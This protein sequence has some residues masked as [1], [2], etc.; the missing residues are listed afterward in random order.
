MPTIAEVLRESGIDCLYHITSRK[1]W[2]TIKSHGLLSLCTLSEKTNGSFEVNSDRVTR[3]LSHSRGLDKYVHLSFSETPPFLEIAKRACLLDEEPIILKISLDVFNN[4]ETVVYDTNPLDARATY[5]SSSDFVEDI[6]LTAIRIGTRGN[7]TSTTGN[8]MMSAT[9]LVKNRIPA[10]FIINSAEID[11]L[12]SENTTKKSLLFLVVDQS[13]S[14]GNDAYQACN[15]VNSLISSILLSKISKGMVDNTFDF[16]I[17][18]YG[19]EVR[20]GWA[21]G[22]SNSPIHPSV[23]VYQELIAHLFDEGKNTKWMDPVANGSN[24]MADKAMAEAYHILDEWIF[25]NPTCNRPIV[26]HITNGRSLRFAP[27]YQEYA[28]RLGGLT[29]SQ[30]KVHLLNYLL[31]ESVPSMNFPIREEMMDPYTKTLFDTSSVI[32]DASLTMPP[33]KLLAVNSGL[34]ESVSLLLSVLD[35]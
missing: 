26:I 13:S 28:L 31:R 6:N 7:S 2:L 15:Q 30:G 21:R 25:S 18:T 10:D 24:V 8:R 27:A 9:V 5:S 23:E 1:N 3:I 4:Q 34:K 32:N 17:I 29:C 19:S 22:L 16:G 12:L 14:M 20:T 11:A 33:R 35:G